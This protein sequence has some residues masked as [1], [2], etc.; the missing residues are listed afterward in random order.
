MERMENASFVNRPMSILL[1]GVRGLAALA[2]LCG[3]AVQIGIYDGWYPFSRTVQHNAV[4]VFFVLSGLVIA[5]SV[6]RRHASLPDYAA[7]RVARIV[8]VAVLAV[9]F[10]LLVSLYGDAARFG[11]PWPGADMQN[12]VLPLFFLSESVIGASLVWNPPYWSL[13]YE[14][15]YYALFGAAVFLHGRTRWLW[16]ALLALIAGWKVLLLLPV[17]LIGAALAGETRR[18]PLR[19]APLGIA[20][21]AGL[22]W[23]A[24]SSAEPVSQMFSAVSGLHILELGFSQYVLTDILLGIGV[25]LIFMGC[26]P[27]ADKFAGV[28]ERMRAPL[29]WIAGCSFTLYVL[30]WPLLLVLRGHGLVAGDNPLVFAAIMAGVVA[31]CGAMAS[32]VE[33]RSPKIKAWLLA[34]GSGRALQPA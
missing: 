5:H 2:V 9:G 22:G 10:S 19:S 8:P 13:V 34:R 26:A 25:A 28:L 24:S 7:A 6:Q 31:L 17:W 4:I 1:D 32:L 21:G 33:R 23:L 15:W 27:L 18:L 20:V 30:H 3:H 12:V 14:V 16:C 29:V 11:Y